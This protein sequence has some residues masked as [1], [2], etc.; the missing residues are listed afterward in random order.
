ML[1][2]I[3]EEALKSSSSKRGGAEKRRL[4]T[5][6]EIARGDYIEVGIRRTKYYQDKS[7][8]ATLKRQ[9]EFKKSE[10]RLEPIRQQ[11]ADTQAK[12]LVELGGFYGYKEMAW[13]NRDRAKILGP[14]VRVMNND[15]LDEETRVAGLIDF[16]DYLSTYYVAKET[17]ATSGQYDDFY[18]AIMNIKN[19]DTRNRLLGALNKLRDNGYIG[20]FWV[21]R[22]NEREEQ[23]RIQY[24]QAMERWRQEHPVEAMI[25]GFA[26]GLA[27]WANETITKPLIKVANV[28]LSNFPVVNQMYKRLGIDHFLEN[29]MES[30]DRTLNRISTSVADPTMLTA[31]MLVPEI[32]TTLVGGPLTKGITAL[33]TASDVVDIA[34]ENQII[35]ESNE[36][37]IPGIG[38]RRRKRSLKQK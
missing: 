16:V 4:A 10:E 36:L 28:I 25:Y 1:R 19:E 27:T 23:R 13:R 24:E 15:S 26:T 9:E 35:K 31:G 8:E 17:P 22:I 5:P 21:Q 2:T 7:P 30:Y 12:R 20:T 3:L 32:A 11:L 33:K 18:I 14:L 6:D 34:K 37:N 29:S 38:G